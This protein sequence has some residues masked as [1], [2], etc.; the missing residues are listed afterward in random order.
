[1]ETFYAFRN[2]Y[3]RTLSHGEALKLSYSI[4]KATTR[5]DLPLPV[6]DIPVPPSLNTRTVEHDR[7]TPVVLNE[8][9]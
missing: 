6:Y 4:K 3:F 1:E 2:V 5:M 9:L 7:A 8:T